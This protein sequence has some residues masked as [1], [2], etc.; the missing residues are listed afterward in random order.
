VNGRDR[1]MVVVVV[2]VVVAA[3][4]A[5]VVVGGGVVGVVVV[6]VVVVVVCNVGDRRMEG[7]ERKC[8]LSGWVPGCLSHLM[9][10]CHFIS[11]YAWY[12]T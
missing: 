1:E 9:I 6:V 5:S 7:G 11:R 2:V 8:V 4:A 10:E 3:A 12:I